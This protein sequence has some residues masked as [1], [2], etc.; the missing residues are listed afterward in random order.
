MTKISLGLRKIKAFWLSHHSANHVAVSHVICLWLAP[1]SYDTTHSTISLFD[2]GLLQCEVLH[3][4]DLFLLLF[5]LGSLS[6]IEI[7]KGNRLRLNVCCLSHR[8]MFLKERQDSPY[9]TGYRK[10]ACIGFAFRYLCLHLARENK[11]WSSFFFGLSWRKPEITNSDLLHSVKRFCSQNYFRSVAYRR[12]LFGD[13]AT[14]RGVELTT[15][16]HLLLSLQGSVLFVPSLSHTPLLRGGELSTK[17]L[18]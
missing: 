7:N 8:Q 4:S 12:S 10:S 14:D 11:F 15:S 13:T 18:M 3:R 2:F 17:I 1:C 9:T 5:L 6:I 16:F